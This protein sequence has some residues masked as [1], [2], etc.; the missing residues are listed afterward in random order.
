MWF[1]ELFADELFTRSI[2][3]SLNRRM[4]R[5]KFARGVCKMFNP[6][7]TSDHAVKKKTEKRK[8]SKLFLST[9]VVSL[10]ISGLCGPLGNSNSLS[11]RR[12]SF[13]VVSARRGRERLIRRPPSCHGFWSVAISGPFCLLLLSSLVACRESFTPQLHI[14]RFQFSQT[15]ENKKVPR[16][17]GN[18][19]KSL[20][21]LTA[22]SCNYH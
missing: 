13:R 7:I 10:T 8:P 11:L 19:R 1:S 9:L 22:Y 17:K 21:L 14:S 2:I 6:R 20:F 16:K 12:C 4:H 15:R 18:R 5:N 3:L